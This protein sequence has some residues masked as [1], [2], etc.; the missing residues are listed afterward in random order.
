MLKV[1]RRIFSFSDW[2]VSHPNQPPPGDMLDA[3][4]TE[5]IDRVDVWEDRIRSV[6]TE[7]GKVAHGAITEHSLTPGLAKQLEDDI[8][9]KI[10]PAMD[11]LA[12]AM[13]LA[14]QLRVQTARD[15][16]EARDA[17]I[18]VGGS[19]A[20]LKDRRDIALE[21]VNAALITAQEL[22]AAARQAQDG[23]TN[24]QKDAFAGEQTAQN[25]AVASMDWAEYMPGPLPSDIIAMMGITGDH[26]SSRWWANY[27][28]Q[29]ATGV[30]ADAARAEIAKD[31]AIA[32]AAAAEAAKDAAMAADN[33]AAES[34]AGAEAA[35]IAAEA[36]RDVAVTAK[37]ATVA[38]ADAAADLYDQFDDRYLGAKE[39]PPTTDNDG[40]PLLEGALYWN[41]IVKRT[42]VWTGSAWQAVGSGS[43][44]AGGAAIDVTFGPSGTL[45]STNVQA[46]LQEVDGDVQ[47]LDARLD[48][49]EAAVVS[50]DS[51]ADALE[52]TDVTLDARLDALETGATGA[53]G[54]DQR[55]D[56]IEADLAVPPAWTEITGKPATFPPSSHGHPQSEI[57]NL[58][59]DLAGKAPTVHTHTTAQVTG[60]DTALA[61][62]A[63][64]AS[65]ALTGIPTTPSPAANDNSTQIATT[66]FVVAATTTGGY[67]TQAAIVDADALFGNQ[68]GT[69]KAKWL[70]STL[71]EAAR[72]FIVGFANV[73]TVRQEFSGGSDANAIAAS[74]ST[75][76][77]IKI[78][79]SVAGGA[80][81]LGFSTAGFGGFFGIDSDSVW[82]VGGWSMG[83]NA[84]K[85]LHE[86]LGVAAATTFELVSGLFIKQKNFAAPTATANY[87]PDTTAQSN[88]RQINAPAGAWTLNAPGTTAEAFTMVALI[89]NLNGVATC[90][91]A[92]FSK[93]SGDAMPTSASALALLYITRIGGQ[94]TVF[95]DKISGTSLLREEIAD[96]LEDADIVGTHPELPEPET[97][98]GV[99]N[100]LPGYEPPVEDRKPRRG[101]TAP[102][103]QDRRKR[104]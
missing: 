103:V 91:L 10:Q 99:D 2:S 38:A 62:K 1:I 22:I 65:P 83:A 63:P 82:K 93:V 67:P 43:G 42:E 40:D 61:A 35:K 23:W 5:I 36:A 84:Y 11:A 94:C 3:Q 41:S 53:G 39:A 71:K 59:S 37:D 13:T 64:L 56:A 50:L 28:A 66:N 7:D 9:L 32:E 33:N 21:D 92:G 52:A 85:L 88:I 44:G 90:T 19:L 95:V 58:V 29:L 77:Q 96:A 4:F 26:W 104:K 78:F 48:P 14:S 97:P 15:A 79:N 20:E 54:F 86:G 8:A 47:A 31:T 6:V 51:R 69:G 73:F 49:V 75:M 55:L 89:Y 46:A 34:A 12:V 98:P 18:V 101:K 24:A 30:D 70:W 81:R 80:A 27:T 87:T 60:L 102:P 57:T 76:G 17:A 68:S 72:V 74:N 45:S 16:K 25:W 100:T